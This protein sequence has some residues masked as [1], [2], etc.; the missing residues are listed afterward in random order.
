MRRS[1]PL[2]C[3]AG[4]CPDRVVLCKPFRVD[5]LPS[6][7]HAGIPFATLVRFVRCGP[8]PLRKGGVILRWSS[9]TIYEDQH[10]G[11]W[12]KIGQG[13]YANVPKTRPRTT[14]AACGSR[15]WSSS[16]SALVDRFLNR[17]D[18]H[19][20]LNRHAL[21]TGPQ[22]TNTPA[23]CRKCGAPVSR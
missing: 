7:F 5:V 14:T 11:K 18:Y 15:V 8:P 20:N 19:R 1:S 6:I 10:S 9:E 3:H 22:T 17:L 2:R 21:R 13:W 12:C 4:T 23:N 16:A